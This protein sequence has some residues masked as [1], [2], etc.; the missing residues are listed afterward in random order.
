MT[1]NNKCDNIELTSPVYFIK[2]VTCYVRFSQQVE[3][4][5]MMKANFIVSIDRDAFGGALL[6]N[7]RWKMDTSMSTQ[8]LIIWGYNP[9]GIYSYTFLIEHESTLNWDKDKLKRLYDAHNNLYDIGFNARGW[10]LDDN[11]R[12]KTV[13][14]ASHGSFRIEVIISE[15]NQLPPQKPLWINPNR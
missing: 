8:L 6:Y 11:T 14:K 4:K 3:P 2:D 7:L 5:C 12:L 1:I 9:V 10:L 13:S 15:E